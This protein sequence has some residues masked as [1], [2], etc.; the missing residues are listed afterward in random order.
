MLAPAPGVGAH[1]GHHAYV[2]GAPGAPGAGSDAG[3]Q[4][5]LSKHCN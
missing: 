3:I 1:H 4:S 5:I 2:M